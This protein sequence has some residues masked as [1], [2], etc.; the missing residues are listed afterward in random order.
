M[1]KMQIDSIIPQLNPICSYGD[2]FLRISDLAWTRF[3]SLPLRAKLRNRENGSEQNKRNSFRQ[4]KHKDIGIWL[5]ELD[6]EQYKDVFQKF[7]G[8]E[9]LLEYSEADI[10]NLGVKK[11]S[12][13]AL[14]ITSLTRLRA[15]YHGTLSRF[16]SNNRT[17]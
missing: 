11:S 15:K 16:F 4:T 14:I 12:H 2:T 10:K 1:L 3:G 17:Y 9:E 13:R 6:L 8:V 7:N 5:K